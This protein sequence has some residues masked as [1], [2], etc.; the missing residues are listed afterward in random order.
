MALYLY[1]NMS[2]TKNQ[3]KQMAQKEMKSLSNWPLVLLAQNVK[4]DQV[5]PWRFSKHNEKPIK[6]AP[7]RLRIK[8]VYFANAATFKVSLLKKN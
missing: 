1:S 3:A 4:V 7:G 6:S 5:D 2:L 8:T